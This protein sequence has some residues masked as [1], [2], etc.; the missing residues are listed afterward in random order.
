MFGGVFTSEAT[1]PR[2]LRVLPRASLIRAAFEGLCVN[3]LRGLA[4]DAAAPGDA[5]SGEQVLRRLA[6][7]GSS[8][9]GALAA[10]AR[11]LAAN[12][13]ATFCILR[14]RRPAYQ[15]LVELEYK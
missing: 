13:A 10:Q 7:E 12:Y 8:L 6:F 15:A 1:V 3:D 4:F 5:A 11:I 9:R 2:A 14:A